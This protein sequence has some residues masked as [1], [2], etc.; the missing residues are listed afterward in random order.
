MEYNGEASVDG[1][2]VW[3]EENADKK[4]KLGK[5]GEGEAPPK[6]PPID[7][8]AVRDAFEL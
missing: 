3:L 5:K 4:F 6:P 2:M 7:E 8:E 1:V